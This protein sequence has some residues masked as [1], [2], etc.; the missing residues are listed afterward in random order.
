MPATLT[1]PAFRSALTQTLHE[2]LG[3]DGCWRWYERRTEAQRG[4][5][6][7]PVLNKLRDFL[8][9][10]RLRRLLCQPRSTV[11]LG[12]V[13]NDGKILLADLNVGR[14]GETAAALVG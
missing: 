10:P 2:P 11:D 6:I 12:R 3:L 8:I 4:E 14:W 1:V 5:A 7:G 9:R 13:V